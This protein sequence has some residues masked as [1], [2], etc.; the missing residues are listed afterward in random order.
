MNLIALYR[1][2][3]L[4]FILLIFYFVS[5]FIKM[6]SNKQVSLNDEIKYVYRYLRKGRKV[7]TFLKQ[8]RKNVFRLF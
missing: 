4:N 2:S 3:I 7:S 5:R 8:R 6:H 1:I